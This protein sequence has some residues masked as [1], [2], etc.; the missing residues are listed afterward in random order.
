MSSYGLKHG[1]RNMKIK[2]YQATRCADSKIG[3]LIAEFWTFLQYQLETTFPN[4]AQTIA[5]HRNATALHQSWSGM[6]L[7]QLNLLL[8]MLGKTKSEAITLTRPLG[9][10]CI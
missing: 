9:S 7:L 10:E 3:S 8:P 6:E 2:S 4:P 5:D 1:A